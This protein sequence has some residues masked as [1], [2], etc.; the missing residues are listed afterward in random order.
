[1]SR[2][3]TDDM[4]GKPPT[5]EEKRQARQAEQQQRQREHIVALIESCTEV[6]MENVQIKGN[7]QQTIYYYRNKC[8][9]LAPLQK[10]LKR[11]KENQKWLL[12]VHRRIIVRCR[13]KMR[14]QK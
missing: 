3:I 1:M 13:K 10:Q 4:M 7:I 5:R 8:D 2:I 12:D 14:H 9:N 11:L 6:E